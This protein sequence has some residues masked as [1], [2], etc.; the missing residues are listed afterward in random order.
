MLN[1]LSKESNV[2]ASLKK[3]FVDA[4]GNV[5]TFDTTL[6][7]PNIR[8]QGSNAVKQ[9]YNINFRE[10]GRQTLAEYFFDV[11]ILSR[12][13]P[14]GVKLAE[15]TDTIMDLLVDNTMQDGMR[16][17]PLYDITKDPWELIGSMVV[18]DISD[19][20]LYLPLE[21]ETKAKVLAVR[22][23]WGAAI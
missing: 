21:D 2:K 9:W 18:Q 3:Y 7:S 8:V 12:Q 14:E 20:E 19:D 4:L 6:A 5:V 16:R 23:R 22:L 15:N 17:I 11:Y 10:F 1:A 13:D